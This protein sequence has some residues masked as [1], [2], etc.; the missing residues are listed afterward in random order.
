MLGNHVH[1]FNNHF[2]VL[3]IYR[4][5]FA[6]FVLILTGD[7]FNGIAFFNFHC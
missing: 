1:A 6:F 5:D 4:K 3:L 7:Y 2:A